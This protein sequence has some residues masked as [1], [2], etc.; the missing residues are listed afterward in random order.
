MIIFV[1]AFLSNATHLL[2]EKMFSVTLCLWSSNISLNSKGLLS[3][4]AQ[5]FVGQSYGLE[6]SMFN[7]SKICIPEFSRY[8]DE[9]RS[10][11]HLPHYN[12]QIKLSLIPF[13]TST[14][15]YSYP[16]QTCSMHSD[17]SS[18]T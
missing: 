3:G 11:L 17:I 18:V 8:T 13:L 12:L 15:Y 16:S 4:R 5:G 7:L 9:L 1:V 10:F 2:M 14:Y 6:V